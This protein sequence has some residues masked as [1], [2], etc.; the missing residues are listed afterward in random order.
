MRANPSAEGIPNTGS[1]TWNVPADLE[2]TE[3]EAAGYGIRLDID[4]TGN[5]QYSTQFG[6]KGGVKASS[7]VVAPSSA[8]SVA[9][10]VAPSS[11]PVVPGPAGVSKSQKVIYSTETITATSCACTEGEKEKPQP[12]GEV[13]PPHS[14]GYA[15]PSGTGSGF[16][17]KNGTST[18]VPTYVKPTAVP[19]PSKTPEVY[20]GAAG[21]LQV[22][23]AALVVMFASMVALF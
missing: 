15:K 9:P 21:K 12:T 13:Q 10:S 4:A 23:G 8:P 2:A 5:Y 6:V 22:G 17:P 18:A 3:T 11:A 19:S 16:P 14:S 7:S 20:E 1:F